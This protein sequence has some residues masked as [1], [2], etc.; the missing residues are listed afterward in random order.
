MFDEDIDSQST[1][2]TMFPFLSVLFCTIGAL[3]VIMIIGSMLTR[4]RG[5]GVDVELKDLRSLV[6]NFR[7]LDN[8][9]AKMEQAVGEITKAEKEWSSLTTDTAS[10]TSDREDEETGLADL[11]ARGS[12]AEKFVKKA[13]LAM[14]R[15][16]KLA[17]SETTFSKW[18]A[19]QKEV[20]KREKEKEDLSKDIRKAK[21]EISR[22]Q[23]EADRPVVH[24]S[25]EEDPQGRRPVLLELKAEGVLVRSE[26]APRDKGVMVAEAEK[27]AKSDF[28]DRL[29][30]SLTRPGAD[31]YA[32]L[33]VRP[34]AADLFFETTDKLRRKRAPYSAEPV[35][36]N[37]EL[38]ID[39][40]E[41]PSD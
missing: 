4:F 24:F 29:A 21:E 9:V 17:A 26:G 20:A 32:I 1:P 12:D 40:G 14:L 36:A 8:Y 22:L 33:F 5:E 41:A 27:S 30:A 25:F 3:V 2:A 39:T 13:S 16:S 10:F 31:R 37:W 6:G 7:Q 34:G 18:Q 19:T 23:G 38:V 28:L 35:E 11:K 15:H